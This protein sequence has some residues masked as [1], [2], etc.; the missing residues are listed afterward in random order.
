MPTFNPLPTLLSVPIFYTFIVFVPVASALLAK[1]A[2]IPVG[3]KSSRTFSIILAYAVISIVY[4]LLCFR[5]VSAYLSYFDYVRFISYYVPKH[6]LLDHYV[7][8]A[9]IASLI[10]VLA[11]WTVY[12]TSENLKTTGTAVRL[13]ARSVLVGLILTILN[14]AL[15]AAVGGMVAKLVCH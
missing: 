2:R 15:F 12:R 7:W 3:I 4:G 9:S 11:L 6:L 5:C 8:Y 13:V 14:L 1:L 10:L